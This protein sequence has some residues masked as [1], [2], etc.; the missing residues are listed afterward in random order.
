MKHARQT[1]DD[2]E[3]STSFQE[4]KHINFDWNPRNHLENQTPAWGTVNQQFKLTTYTFSSFE[5]NYM[6]VVATC[7]HKLSMQSIWWVITWI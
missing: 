7:H 4:T 5:H 3:Q 1:D 6:H 2:S